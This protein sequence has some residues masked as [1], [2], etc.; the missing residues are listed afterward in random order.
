MVSPSFDTNLAREQQPRRGFPLAGQR[1]RRC[2]A[3][4]FV[5]GPVGGYG[6][7][8]QGGLYHPCAGHV[9]FKNGDVS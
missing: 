4:R 8:F 7:E 6:Q 1:A 2:A 5:A 3:S 9:F